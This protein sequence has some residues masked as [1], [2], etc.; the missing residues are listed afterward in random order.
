[1]K[2][3]LANSRGREIEPMALQ[4]QTEIG[5]HRSGHDAATSRRVGGMYCYHGI[6]N[7]QE[8]G[9]VQPMRR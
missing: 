4:I 1:M 6:E 5:T 8:W 7:E 2:C 3:P 9:I